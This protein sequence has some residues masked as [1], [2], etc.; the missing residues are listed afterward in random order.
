QAVAALAFGAGRLQAVDKIVG[1]GNAYVA[2]AKRQV[3]GQVGID[4]IAGPS[5]ILVIADETANPAWIA[6]DLLSQSEHDLSSQSIL[7]ST[8]EAVVN[9]VEEAVESQLKSLST[10][11]RARQAWD[12]HGAFILVDTLEAAAVVANQIAAE[13]LELAIADPEGLLPR[14]KHAGAVFLGHHTPEAL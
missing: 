13:H 11:A 6:A 12:T 2:E 14:I 7:I 9:S 5:E 4:T 3:F 8:S 10:E 1:P